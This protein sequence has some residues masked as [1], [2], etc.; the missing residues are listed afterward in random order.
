MNAALRN[1]CF[2]HLRHEE[3]HLQEATALLQALHAA[4]LQGRWSELQEQ[5]PAA[6]DLADRAATLRADRAA[7][8]LELAAGLG[9]SPEKLRLGVLVQPYPALRE[10]TERVSGQAV[11]LRLLSQ[12][13]GRLA[14]HMLG[15]L[16][17]IFI[18]LAG[19]QAENRSYGP[20]G[21]LRPNACGSLIEVNG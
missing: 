14:H 9:V 13:H 3:R 15:C 7:C 16:Q 5:L 8:R 19:G 21:T 2:D 10:L 11:T 17:G 20:A 6:Q 4:A 12:R 1:R 18:E